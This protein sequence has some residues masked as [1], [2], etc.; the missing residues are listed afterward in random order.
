MNVVLYQ[1]SE[2]T[3]DSITPCTEGICTELLARECRSK[4]NWGQTIR[5]SE[6]IVCEVPETT[7]IDRPG[8]QAFIKPWYAFPKQRLSQGSETLDHRMFSNAGHKH[9]K[10]SSQEPKDCLPRCTQWKRLLVTN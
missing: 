1:P 9:N 2:D 7:V 10:S 8:W 5:V 4:L 3:R 6:N